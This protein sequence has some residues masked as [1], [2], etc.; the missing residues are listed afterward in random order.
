MLVALFTLFFL[1]GGG[2]SPLLGHV[3]LLID[4]A[5]ASIESEDRRS[6]AVELLKQHKRAAKDM[7]KLQQ[8]RAKQLGKLNENRELDFAASDAIWAAEI[9]ALEAYHAEVL[10]TRTE[11]KA[12]VNRDE[13]STVFG[14]AEGG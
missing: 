3:D 1:S 9:D 10:A 5:K 7:N 6:E 8:D 12:V 2:S 13:W 4:N 14:I 11:L